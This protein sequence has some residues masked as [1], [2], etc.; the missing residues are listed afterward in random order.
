[1]KAKWNE[2]KNSIKQMRVDKR[3]FDITCKIISFPFVLLYHILNFCLTFSKVILNVI[4]LVLIIGGIAG[5]ILYAKMLPMYQDACEQAYDKLSNL[6]ENSFHMFS[7]TVIYDKD[8][9][10]IGEID[11]GSYKYVKINKISE[12]IQYGYIATEDKKFMEHRGIDLQSITRAGISL[13]TNKGEIT[14][15]GS[16]ITQQVIK[17][18]LLSQKQSFGRKLTEVLLAPALEQ[19]YNKAD[20]MEFY[21]NSNFYGNRCYKRPC[22]GRAQQVLALV[23]RARLER[24][25]NE[26]LDEL[27]AQVFDVQL[28]RAALFRLLVEGLQLFALPDVARNADHI[29]V[30]I[31]LQPRHDNRG[32]QTTGISQQYAHLRHNNRLLYLHH[33]FHHFCVRLP[34][35]MDYTPK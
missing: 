16:T 13:I 26:V 33:D 25:P 2:W 28:F 7:N 23:D 31:F 19:K 18:N 22:E 14:Q 21:C 1:M 9:K 34:D 4:L 3:W 27:L 29:A 11:S 24:R 10:K 15:G 20:I 6:N 30:I 32:I 8:G 35:K 12:Y 5:G 17:N